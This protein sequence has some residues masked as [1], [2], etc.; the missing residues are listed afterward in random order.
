[1]FAAQLSINDAEWRKAWQEAELD[2]TQ[3]MVGAFITAGMESVAWLRSLTDRIQ[4]PVF[5][6]EGS[7]K[8]HPGNWA[9]ITSNLANAY[10]FEVLHNGAQVVARSV[11][12]PPSGSKETPATVRATTDLAD[13]SESFRAASE[14]WLL[15]ANDMEYA[16][17]LEHLHG[18]WVL[19]GSTEEGSELVQAFRDAGRALGFDIRG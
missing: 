15:L 13:V 8:A 12:I 18:Y 6:G 5:A 17:Y 1:M 10:R 11:V 14:V 16:I 3:K 4:P 9:D 2:L 7:R 19:T